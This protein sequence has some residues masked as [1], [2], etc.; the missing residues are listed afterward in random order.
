MKRMLERIFRDAW[1]VGFVVLLLLLLLE[2]LQ[3]GFVSRFFNV[4]WIILFLLVV[5][6]IILSVQSQKES[7]DRRGYA[8][9]QL[10]G[11]VAAL[12]LWIHLPADLRLFWRAVASGGVLV[13][14]LLSWPLVHNR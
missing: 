5:S 2:T 9:L 8:S 11:I 12:V 6:V 4:N 3:R 1:K 10:L 13:V 7:D 14:A